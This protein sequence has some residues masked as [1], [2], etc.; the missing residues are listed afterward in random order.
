MKV[1]VVFSNKSFIQFKFDSFKDSII[2]KI[3]HLFTNNGFFGR[4]IN[5]Q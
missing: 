3:Y 5:N 2:L 4:I 1:Q